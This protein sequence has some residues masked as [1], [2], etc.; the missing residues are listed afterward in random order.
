MESGIHPLLRAKECQHARFPKESREHEA[1]T[2]PASIICDKKL[3]LS[4]EP[5]RSSLKT[6]IGSKFSD[7]TMQRA[8][9]GVCRAR[10]IE[11]Q[12]DGREQRGR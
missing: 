10:R 1:A 12:Q 3:C 11:R 7:K 9:E 4:S 5:A 2:M 6:Q 8:R